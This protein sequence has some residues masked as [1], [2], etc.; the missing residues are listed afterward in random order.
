[1]SVE[2]TSTGGDY[3]YT[4][5]NITQKHS[6]IFIFGNVNYYFITSSGTGC[7]LFPD[8]Q[9]VKLEG[10]GYRLN[11]IPNNITDVV[12]ITDNNIDRTNLLGREDGYDKNNNPAVSYSYVL[13]N[14][15][16]AHNLVI[17]CVAV[18]TDHFYIKENNSWVTV[19]KIYKKENDRWVE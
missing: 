7:R 6:L 19:V 5:T 14:I 15:Q 12:S 1:L 3:T 13:S 9:S 16:A 17:T 2:A 8:G 10:D 18:S 4:L 11:I